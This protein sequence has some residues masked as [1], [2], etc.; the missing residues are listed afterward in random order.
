MRENLDVFSLRGE[1]ALITGGA[2]GL[3]FATASAMI[4][5]GARVVITGRRE[6]ALEEAVTQLG[7]NASWHVHDVTQVERAEHL[8]AEITGQHGTPTIL[9]NNAGIHLK[10]DTAATSCEEF[11]AMIDTHVIG[12]FGITR[13]ALVGMTRIGRGNVVFIA[14]MASLIGMPKVIAYSAAK[15]A[16]LGMVRSLAAEVASAGIRVNAIAPGWI[17]TPMLQSALDNDPERRAKILSR[18]PMNR[19]GDPRDIGWAAV[20]LCSSAAAFVNGITLPVDGGASI[21]F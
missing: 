3:G 21:G 20:Y 7:P 6:H 19:F 1:V 12:A 5:A 14:S 9:V 16:Y 18:T 13:A 2:T 15:S 11:R 10:K 17:E 8:V 4:R